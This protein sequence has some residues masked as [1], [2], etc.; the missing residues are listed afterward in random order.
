MRL[1]PATASPFLATLAR[2][3]A[4]LLALIMLAW[5]G[6]KVHDGV[7][8]LAGLGRGVRTREPPCSRGSTQPRERSAGSR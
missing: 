7:D 3:A 6:F 8:Q 1:Y 5:L 4:V 2:D